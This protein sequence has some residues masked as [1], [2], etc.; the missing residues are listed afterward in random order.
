MPDE[1]TKPSHLEQLA[2]EIVESLDEAPEMELGQAETTPA[3]PTR[4][5]GPRGSF[6]MIPQKAPRVS[7]PVG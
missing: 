1:P 3:V 6:V 5:Q 7:Q 4:G 2:D